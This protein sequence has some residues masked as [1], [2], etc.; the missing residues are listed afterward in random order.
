M[1]KALTL[2]GFALVIGG[3]IWSEKTQKATPVVVGITAGTLL[4]IYTQY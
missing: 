1:K 2:L 3:A 4:F